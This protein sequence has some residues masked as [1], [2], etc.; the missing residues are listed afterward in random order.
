MLKWRRQKIPNIPGIT[1]IRCVSRLNKTKP[2]LQAKSTFSIVNCKKFIARYLRRNGHQVA[3]SK[4]KTS[5]TYERSSVEITPTL[6]VHFA[7]TKI[8]LKIRQNQGFLPIDLLS[9][10]SSTDELDFNTAED[11]VA[12]CNRSK[13]Q[14]K[15]RKSCPICGLSCTELN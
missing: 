5:C 7:E 12:K 11:L 3:T 15:R 10:S 9:L 1:S 14:N 2:K 13:K 4:L 8:A 6:T